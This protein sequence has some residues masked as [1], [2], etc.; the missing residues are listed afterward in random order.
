MTP[1]SAGQRFVVLVDLLLERDQ[2]DRFMPLLRANAAASLGHE[3]GCS[4]FDICV[5]V[6]TPERVVL[7]EIYDSEAAFGAH[8]ASA[9]FKQFDAETSAMIV[10]KAVRKLTLA[11][12]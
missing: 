11:A 7:Y 5:D 4:R 1:G 6:A 10:S 3:P 12:G 9:H 2:L 8:L